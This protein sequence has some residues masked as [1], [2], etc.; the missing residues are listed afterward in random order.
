MKRTM[1]ALFAVL[2]V[3]L[4]S[5]G[6]AADQPLG[7][8]FFTPEQRARMDVARQQERSIRIDADQADNAPL[9][10]NVTLNGV[11]TRSDG[12]STVWIN[13][14]EQSPGKPGS[15]IVAPGRGKP[16]GQVSVTTPDAKRS[17]PLKVGQSVDLNSGQ[18]EEVYRRAPPPSPSGRKEALP[19]GTSDR[20]PP[21][22]KS[23][24]R[25]RDAQDAP[26]PADAQGAVPPPY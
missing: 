3:L 18:V 21:A 15:A 20:L 17:I 7:R 9:D 5:L 23:P 6:L 14:R 10:A 2:L 8:L 4:P 26:E 13:N 25:S 12:Q 1:T 24:S 16:A 22:A 19:S 11:V